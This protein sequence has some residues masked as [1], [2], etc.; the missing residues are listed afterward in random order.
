MEYTD[1]I[2]G[3]HCPHCG[4]QSYGEARISI[5]DLGYPIDNVYKECKCNVC[6]LGFNIKLR[7]HHL[8]SIHPDPRCHYY[9]DGM[10]MESVNVPPVEISKVD[11]QNEQLKIRF[12]QALIF[13]EDHE[14]FRQMLEH[15]IDLLDESMKVIQ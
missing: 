7:E 11:I 5:S 3:A 14:H 4:S 2:Y 9:A 10:N 12:E 1:S 6:K 15:F 8:V 13:S